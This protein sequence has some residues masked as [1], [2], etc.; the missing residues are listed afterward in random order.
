MTLNMRQFLTTL[1]IAGASML[2][3]MVKSCVRT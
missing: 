2:G 3:A 1:S